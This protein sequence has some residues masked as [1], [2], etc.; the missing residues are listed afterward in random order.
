MSSRP[1]V[2]MRLIKQFLSAAETTVKAIEDAF[3]E[4]TGREVIS[5]LSNLMSIFILQS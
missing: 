5:K 3:R 1:A 4:F 2:V